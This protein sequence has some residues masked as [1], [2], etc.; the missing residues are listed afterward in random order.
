MVNIQSGTVVVNISD[1]IWVKMNTLIERLSLMCPVTSG[2]SHFGHKTAQT[3]NI[4]T[5]NG[6]GRRSAFPPTFISLFVS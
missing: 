2:L 1:N 3:K 5:N 4:S 6:A